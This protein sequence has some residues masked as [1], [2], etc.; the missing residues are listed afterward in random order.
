L[1]AVSFSTIAQPD[2]DGVL[3][4]EVPERAVRSL[5]ER[6]RV[7]VQVTLNG[8]KYRSTIAV[9]GGR[10]YLPARKEIRERAKLEPGRR[11]RISL[12]LDTAPRNV[13]IPA[14]LGRALKAAKFGPAFERLSYS[15]RREYVDAVLAAKRPET[16][17]ARVAKAIAA[18]RTKRP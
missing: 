13:E 18:L 6:K 8:V 10:Y 3:L 5:G 12:E 15:H 17:S 4:I 14:D 11:A 1:S 7:R 9:Y 2:P 16:R